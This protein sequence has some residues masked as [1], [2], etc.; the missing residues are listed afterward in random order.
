MTNTPI[1]YRPLT[2]DDIHRMIDLLRQNHHQEAQHHP[3]YPSFDAF[4]PSL[5]RQLTTLVNRSGG[6]AALEKGQLCGYMI[7]VEI[8][9]LFGKDQGLVISAH[10]WSVQGSPRARITNELLTRVL[11]DS[12]QHGHTSIAWTISA[13]DRLAISVARDLGFGNRC[14]DALR[15]THVGSI[16]DTTY[17]IER[18]T[19]SRLEVIAPLHQAHNRYYRQAPLWMPNPEEDPLEDLKGWMSSED[20][21]IWA[22]FDQDHPVGYLRTQAHAESYLSHHPQLRNITAAYVDPMFRNRGVAT[23]LLNQALHDLHDHGIT[24]C[25]VDYET[26]NPSGSRFW[27]SQFKPYTISLTRRIDERILDLDLPNS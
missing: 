12:V 20:R 10:G 11:N 13:H 6:W 4:Q 18:L 17:R 14:A 23:E 7:G 26:I 25:G 2:S 8:G 27:S 9:E 1:T 19:P 5:E 15:T 24:W 22:A 21:W 3:D 16:K